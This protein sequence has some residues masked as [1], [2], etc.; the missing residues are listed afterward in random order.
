MFGKARLYFKYE[1]SDLF[2][3]NLVFSFLISGS[4]GV[5]RHATISDY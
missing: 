3:L 1:I 2:V 5:E 4:G